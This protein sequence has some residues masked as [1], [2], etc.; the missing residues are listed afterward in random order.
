MHMFLRLGMSHTQGLEINVAKSRFS[1]LRWL[2]HA[3]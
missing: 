2:D 3:K 1:S